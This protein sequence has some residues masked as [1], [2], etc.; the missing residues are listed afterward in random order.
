MINRIIQ[1]NHV[2]TDIDQITE[3]LDTIKLWC[4]V[5]KLISNYVMINLKPSNF[6]E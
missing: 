4:F 5:N 1:G 3:G 6:L 2:N